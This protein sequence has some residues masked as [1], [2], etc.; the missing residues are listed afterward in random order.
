M[1][2][3]ENK[4]G[5]KETS[6]ASNPPHDPVADLSN[7]TSAERKKLLSRNKRL[8]CYEQVMVLY[9]EGL[10]QRTIAHSLHLSRNTVR[11]YLSSP[12]FPERAEGTRRRNARTSK[13]VSSLPFVR[14]Q[15]EAGNHNGANLF[16]LI[17]ARGYTDC[18]SLLRMR[19]SEWR[20]ELPKQSWPGN[21]RKP[22]LF[23]QQKQR[24]LSSRATSFLMILPPEK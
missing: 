24:C 18:E 16:R 17:K 13:L 10:S 8:A 9:R 23:T 1:D 21:P 4:P 12:G 11:R 7:L 14:E 3:K 2:A 20:T 15:W 22:R 19:L 6:Q 5:G